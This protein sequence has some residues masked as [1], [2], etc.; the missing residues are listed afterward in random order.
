MG[1]L[2]LLNT[3]GLNRAHRRRDQNITDVAVE[4]K[5]ARSPVATNE[6]T[7]SAISTR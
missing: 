7:A 1:T 3:S 6:Q 2:K 4:I 5:K